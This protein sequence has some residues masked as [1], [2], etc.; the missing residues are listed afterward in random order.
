[1]RLRILF[2]IITFISLSYRLVIAVDLVVPDEYE[3]IMEA[4]EEAEFGDTVVVKEGE[5]N[6]R[7]KIVKGVNL[8]SYAGED[9]NELVDGPGNKKILKRTARTIID[10]TDIEEAG[11]L[12]S[13]P[14]DT[15]APMRLDGFTIRNMPKYETGVNY[16]LVEVR[17]CS[18]EVVNLVV[19]G[20]KSWGG[21]LATG[22][23]VGMG[24][25]LETTAKPVIANNVVYNNYGPGIA[26][27][28][29]ST[30]LV[31]ENEV[32]ENSFPGAGNTDS[33]AACIG[34]RSYARPV[35][36]NNDCYS[37]G[38]GVGGLN[39]EDY[40]DTLIIRGNRLRNNRRAGIG[41]R[42]IDGT[43]TNIKV[44]VE[45][46]EIYNNLKAGIMMQKVD[47]VTIRYNNIYDN[48]K[49]G[50]I[51]ANVDQLIMYN[52]EIFGNLTAGARFLDVPI[53]T[54]RDNNIYRNVTAG[55]DF[56]GWKR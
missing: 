22:L 26:N 44:L 3:T 48:R 54:I 37:C 31:T 38:S 49:A 39:M 13:F 10:G 42:I 55:I 47:N 32:F 30:A 4:M 28:A 29:N 27:G 7:V 45:N 52:N 35:I 18:P 12:V 2:L 6:E 50:V 14:Y 16:F 53:V 24:P 15:P 5:Y 23:G 34:M 43:D 19:T 20:N 11:Y 25:A 1:M 56:I 40:K 8:V 41:I 21:I 46:N 17:G 36:E 9:G 33:D 51:A